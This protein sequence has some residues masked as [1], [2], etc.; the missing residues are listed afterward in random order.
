MNTR[1][2]TLTAG[3]ISLISVVSLSACWNSLSHGRES[4]EKQKAAVSDTAAT[5][6]PR[7]A[8]L[9]EKLNRKVRLHFEEVPAG[10]VVKALSHSLGEPIYFHE[11]TKQKMLNHKVTLNLDDQVT[12]GV[13]LRIML[14]QMPFNE[15]G[16]IFD[17]GICIV[18]G[19]ELP[20]RCLLRTYNLGHFSD[21]TTAKRTRLIGQI[22]AEVAPETW[23]EEHGTWILP[24]RDVYTIDVYQ[25]PKVHAKI[26]ALLRYSHPGVEKLNTLQQTLFGAV[27]KRDTARQEQLVTEMRKLVP[28][29]SLADRLAYEKSDEMAVPV[30]SPEAARRLDQRDKRDE[31]SVNRKLPS[32]SRMRAESLRMLHEEQVK[33]FVAREGFGFSRMPRPGPSSIPL[34]RAPRL[35]LASPEIVRPALEVPMRL[36]EKESD[37]AASGVRLPTEKALTA[38]HQTSEERFLD[39]N[40]FGY[41]KDREHVA[42]FKSHAFIY[43]PYLRESESKPWYATSTEHWALHRLELVSLLKHDEPSVYLSSELPRMEELDNVQ[44]REL[45]EF[46]SA[47]LKRLRGGEDVISRATTNRIEMLGSLRATKRCLECHSVRRGHLLGAFSYQLLRDPPARP[48]EVLGSNI[49]ERVER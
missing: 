45:N 13:A 47:A 25:T 31:V 49:D 39:P 5:I 28:F 22:R 15:T 6:P 8:E 9:R 33:D 11:S 20:D 10:E 21:Y 37:K 42:G 24:S 48:E 40:R 2:R 14:S 27:L 38:F 32:W 44:T 41:V 7:H 18:G 34:P 26:E 35:V 12:I 29:K 43:S 46:E 1:L 30:L 17:K 36:P 23:N 3:A 16:L 19:K 4:K